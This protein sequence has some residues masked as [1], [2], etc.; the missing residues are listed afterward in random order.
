MTVEAYILLCLVGLLFLET[1]V[2]WKLCHK[3]KTIEAEIRSMSNII[4][5]MHK[6]NGLIVDNLRDIIKTIDKI[7][8]YIGGRGK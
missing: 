2:I 1:C 6:N 8:N 5:C 4:N 7:V 3:I